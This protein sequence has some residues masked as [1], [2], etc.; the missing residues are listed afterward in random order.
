MAAVTTLAIG[1][2]LGTLYYT[3]P[4]LFPEMPALFAQDSTAT[5][6]P[7]P[8]LVPMKEN[9]EG[10]TILT[11]ATWIGLGL[12]GFMFMYFLLANVLHLFRKKSSEY[13]NYPYSYG[14]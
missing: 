6:T 2:G 11:T 8:A 1:L 4:E 13:D 9:V 3:N 12:V 10:K 14:S 5:P 7:A